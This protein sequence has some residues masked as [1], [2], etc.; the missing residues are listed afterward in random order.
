MWEEDSAGKHSRQESEAPAAPKRRKRMHPSEDSHSWNQADNDS[1]AEEKDPVVVNLQGDVAG[2]VLAVE[3]RYNYCPLDPQQQLPDQAGAEDE[4]S[5]FC[6]LCE[7]V[8]KPS[9]DSKSSKPLED[10]HALITDNYGRIGVGALTTLIQRYY[11]KEIRH[12]II[13]PEGRKRWT[14]KQIL[15]HIE[16]HA[17]N[18]YTDTIRQLRFVRGALT[19][20][21]GQVKMENPDEPSDIKLD[22]T[23]LKMYMLLMKDNHRLSVEAETIASSFK[24]HARMIRE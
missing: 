15:E 17:P 24:G 9:G 8:E 21:S 1:V 22:L 2:G 6:F 11:E 10:L 19:I 23:N 4:N 5:T 14:R 13:N 7:F 16:I 18:R 12:R 3:K 20:L